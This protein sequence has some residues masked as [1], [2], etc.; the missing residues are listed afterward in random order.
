MSIKV[1]IKNFLRGGA[2]YKFYQIEE[3]IA[4]CGHCVES[5]DLFD[6][7]IE[8]CAIEYKGMWA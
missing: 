4:L 5:S 1:E 3:Y 7:C 8:E 2:I 6:L